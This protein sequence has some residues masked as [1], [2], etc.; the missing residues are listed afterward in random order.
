M[1]L[2]QAFDAEAVC[3]R[4]PGFLVLR[5]PAPEPTQADAQPLAVRVHQ[6]RNFGED[7][8][9]LRKGKA[10]PPVRIQWGQRFR[11]ALADGAV[12]TREQLFA[13]CGGEHVA[14]FRSSLIW[15]CGHHVVQV[16]PLPGGALY[17]LGPKA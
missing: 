13:A 10:A 17:R 15:H 5:A 6:G 7:Q 3:D 16:D 2:A 11:A 8:R 14:A 12:L 4:S 9:H 1:N